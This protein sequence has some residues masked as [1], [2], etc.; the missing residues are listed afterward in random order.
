MR[1]NTITKDGDI[2]ISI[3]DVANILSSEQTTPSFVRWMNEVLDKHEGKN[4]KPI[5]TP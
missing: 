4:Q 5:N 2:Y 1:A 3:K